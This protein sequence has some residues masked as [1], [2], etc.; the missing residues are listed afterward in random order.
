MQWK[1][2]GACTRSNLFRIARR[3][4]LVSQLQPVKHKDPLVAPIH[5]AAAAP[6][7]LQCQSVSFTSSAGRRRLQ[8]EAEEEEEMEVTF[9]LS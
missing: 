4:R 2:S 1:S 8:A 6:E 5:P 9:N 3:R 7:C